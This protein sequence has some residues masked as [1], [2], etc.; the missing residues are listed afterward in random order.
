MDGWIFGGIGTLVGISGLIFGWRAELRATRRDRREAFAEEPP[1][2]SDPI[3]VSG[4]VWAFKNEGARTAI[5]TAIVADPVEWQGMIRARRDLPATVGLGD[6]YPVLISGSMAGTP[7]VFIEWH[8][9][10][11]MVTKRTRRAVK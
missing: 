10:G 2:W 3:F 11:D 6:T 7:A 4:S 8:W 1:P 9:Q 5:V